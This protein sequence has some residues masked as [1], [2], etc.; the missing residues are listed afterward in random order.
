MKLKFTLLLFFFSLVIHSQIKGVVKDVD[1]KPL[2]FVNIFE[3]NTYNST[4]TNDLGRF[5]L[6]IKTP[7]KHVIL[8]QYLGYKTSKQVVEISNMPIDLEVTLFEENIT[9][10]EV[11]IDKGINPADEIIRNA[12]K[13][14][15]INTEKASRYTA[16][17]YS[18]G[19]FRV[20]NLPK[21]IL[22]QK[23]DF[24]DEVI[25]STRS[26]ILYLSETVSK[27]TFQKPDKLKEVIIASKVSGNDNGFSFNNAASANFDFYDNYLEFDTN[28]VSPIADNAFNYYKYTFEG[29]FFTENRQQINKIKVLPKRATEPVMSG[30]IYI[31][32]DSY[33][34]YAV[35]VT[36]TGKQIQN[37]ALNTLTLKQSFSYN[38]NTKIWTKN[39]Q[40][41]DFDA[42]MLG[43]NIS[44]RFTYV[45][46]NFEFPEKFEKKTF[47]AEVLRF[48]ENAN[49]KEDSFWN[50]IRPVPLTEE[51]ITDYTKKDALQ[52]KKKSQVYLDSIDDKRNKFHFM[53]VLN[54]YTYSN[55]FKKWRITYDGPI[56]NTS[57]NTI[58]G[59]NTSVGLSFFKR[60]EDKNTYY[61]FGSN[62]AYGFSDEAFRPT[63]Y[64]SAKLNNKS[65]SYLSIY[66]GNIATQF[67]REEPISKLVNTV[68]TLFFKNNFMK[69]YEKNYIAANFSREV[70][71]GLNMSL[72]LEYSE[73]KPL[74]NTTDYTVIKSDDLYTSNNPL[75]PFDFSIP[76]LEKHNLAKLT[77][78]ARIKFGQQY[79]TRPDGKYN[80]SNDKYPTLS[81][82]Y[83]KGF[84]GNESQYNFDKIAARVTQN[85]ILGNKGELS[86]NIKGGK[87]FNADGISFVDYKHFNGNQT[88]FNRG[89]M[90]NSFNLLPYYSSS[91]NDSYFET[92]LE[93]NDKGYIM[94]KIPL[95]NKLQS[96]LMLGFK[97]LAIPERNPYQ[98]FSVGFSNLGFGKFRIF[99]I[100]YIRAYQSGYQGDGVM[101]GLSF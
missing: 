35:D 67:N 62:V 30:Y 25:D 58:Q 14:K 32:D 97:N 2:P 53:D 49:K 18:R 46:S 69:L 19:I 47:T 72:G 59:W 16:D 57:F 76:A 13:N 11:I 5:E 17:F 99:R 93:H 43:V 61:Q 42:G 36:F 74:Y 83:E 71:N 80:I 45:F 4:T 95:L 96:K 1:G 79:I 23:L 81:L 70:F 73:R 50:T 66:G 29:S 77:V 82:G 15:K 20:K 56:M 40:T 41:L 3:E 37:P 78:G 6:N 64:F 44:G 63:A 100:D 91:T 33:A 85:L 88:H 27:V 51:E 22:G 24:F 90:T 26:G 34:I 65:K 92:H 94:N 60:N 38:N 39:T 21:K 54:G 87:F 10:N 68:S 12:I 52:E 75:L 86:I 98:E 84:S 55:S 101:F 9:L 28:V 31:V 48:E 7:G 89:D 8:F